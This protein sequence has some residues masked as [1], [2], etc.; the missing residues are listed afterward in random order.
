M[1]NNTN[2][3]T[4]T[5]TTEQ[6]QAVV[7]T[8][9]SQ[10]TLGQPKALKGE[11]ITVDGFYNGEYQKTQ[12]E[13]HE[14]TRNTNRAWYRAS[15]QKVFGKRIL[16]SITEDELQEYIN[17]LDLKYGTIK[18]Y[19]G[20]LRHIFGY[21]YKKGFISENPACDLRIQRE[22]LEAQ[23]KKLPA[24]LDHYRRL[25]EVSEGDWC[26]IIIPLLFETGMRKEEVLGLRWCDIY[27]NCIHVEKVYTGLKGGRG[28]AVEKNPKTKA[29]RRAIP[30]SDKLMGALKRHK[31]L[32]QTLVNSPFVVSKMNSPE[33]MKPSFFD[34]R[35]R[36]YRQIARIK[37]AI[38]PHS[39]RHYFVC[40]LFEKGVPINE[41]M[42]LTGHTNVKTYMSYAY[43]D[44]PTDGTIEYFKEF[45]GDISPIR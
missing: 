39:A 15:I 38:T 5:M 8:A 22:K 43:V 1:N 42:K 40:R 23:T 36:K 3:N 37:E 19:R 32:Q 34:D 4:I 24:T 29:S 21:A 30:I 27:D 18:H 45:M 13:N 28:K 33:R 14:T 26:C 12:I 31:A 44:K 41:G 11:S 17:D 16:S 2:I 7:A 10:V 6:L 35:F 20:L 25:Y 9:I